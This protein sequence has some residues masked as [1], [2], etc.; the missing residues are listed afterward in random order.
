MLTLWHPSMPFV[1]EHV[2]K[3]AGFDGS[4]ITAPWPA[5]SARAGSGAS[6]ESLRSLVTDMRRLRSE[7][8]VEAAAQVEFGIAAAPDVKKV[9]EENLAVVK[10]LTRA[11]GVV[12]MDA[13][14]SGWAIAVSG[15]TTIALNLAGSVDVEKER[16]KAQKELDETAKYIAATQAK[17]ANEEFTSKAP[18]HVIDGMKVKLTE[19]QA[20]TKALEQKLKTLE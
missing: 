7:Q 20:K 5:A 2:W 1:T 4:L 19:A 9:V 16:A 11:S 15:G 18:A 10:H 17:L 3:T 13:A 14:P 8:G 12:L 6:F